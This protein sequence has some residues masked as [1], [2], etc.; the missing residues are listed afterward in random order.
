MARGTIAQQNF[1]AGEL[2]PS[3]KG[4]FDLAQYYNGGAT[5]R[6]FISTVQGS[7]RYRSGTKF[8]WYTKS[9][10][11]ARLVPFEYNT[12]QAYILEFTNTKMRIYK[13][14][15]LVVDTAKTI[16]GITNANPAVVTSAAHGYSNG[17]SVVISGVVGMTEVNNLEFVVANVAANTFEL[18][19]INSTSYTAYTSGGEAEEIIEVTTPYLAAELFDFQFAQTADTMYIV[20]PSYA[21]YK[22]TRSSHTAWT[23][24]TY[25]ISG[26]PFGTT[27]AAAKVI[28]AITKANPAVVTSAAHGYSNGDTVYIQ[29][30]VGMTEVNKKNFTVANVAANT[31]ELQDYDSTLNTAYTSGGTAEK[32]TAFS[33]PSVVTFF[34]QRLMFAA[35]TSFPQRLWGSRAAQDS[36]DI[37][38][39]GVDVTDAF[40]YTLAS[41]KV[42]EIEW[43]AGTENFLAIGTS[44]TEFKATGGGDENAITPLNVSIKPVSYYGAH[45]I[46]P[47]TLDSHILY[48]QRD[49]NTLRSFE[50]DAVQD[51]Y[52][53]VNRNLTSDQTLRGMYGE[54]DGAKQAAYQSG[55]PSINW[56]VKN[57]GQLAGLTFEPKEQV[58]GWHRH[59]P[60]GS[61]T[62]GK[63]SRAQYESVATIPQ[64]HAPNQTW[65]VVKRTVDGA[66]VRHVEYFADQPNIPQRM[67]YFTG[68]ANKVTDKS[69][70]LLDMFEAQKRLWY[71]DAGVVFDGTVAQTMVLSAVTG[72]GITCTAGGATF[73]ATDV[74]REIW[75]KDG[76]R[77][78]ITAYT[79]STVVTATVTVTFPSVSIAA[80]EWYLTSDTLSGAQHL[81]GESSVVAVADGAIIE[82]I[83][84][85]DNGNVTFASQH[86]YVVLGLPYT[87]LIQLMPMASDSEDGTGAAGV[88]SVSKIG[89]R[90]LD[91]LGAKLGTDPY[92][93]ERINF[94]SSDD[95]IGRPS[96]LFSGVKL[97]NCSDS[98]DLEKYIYLVQD[99][100]QPCNVQFFVPHLTTQ[101][102]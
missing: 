24:A 42:N 79:S 36:Y 84:V 76:G 22:L 29:S 54:S 1:T 97:E 68:H 32:Y 65:V 75:G 12:T 14:G 2:S 74:G 3:L 91:T 40:S 60:G 27:K 35:S 43:M 13:D 47:T 66:T 25:T 39:F 23:L 80:S 15:G 102:G 57:D 45:D 21:P 95:V 70:Y 7:A 88:K 90:F 38:V 99:R 51:G 28:T 101:N 41:G 96:P 6:N 44:G 33:Y 26:N 9:N 49:G 37:F 69:A 59:I 89:V 10:L 93:L 77:A 17:D 94:A 56:V 86:S 64:E 48:F 8:A 78:T 34:E 92:N 58:S 5:F 50:Y 53:S 16:T 30:V 11:A 87:G 31:F 61:L 72:T 71:V 18:T 55:N 81:A 63:L 100:P 46:P 67:D 82:D 19:G 83:D 98:S 4:R 20:H 52:T 73:A 85:D 62:G